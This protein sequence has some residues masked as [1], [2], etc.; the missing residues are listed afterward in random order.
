[1]V[2]QNLTFLNK[3]NYMKESAISAI[4]RTPYGANFSWYGAVKSAYGANWILC[5]AI[6]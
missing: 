3:E 5:P 4:P 2:S 1:M 6:T